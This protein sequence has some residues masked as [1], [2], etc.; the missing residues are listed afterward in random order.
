MLC[1]KVGKYEVKT[2]GPWSGDSGLWRATY[3]IFLI[4]DDKPIPGATGQSEWCKTTQEAH[5]QA[6]E[7]GRQTALK[8]IEIDEKRNA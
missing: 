1:T 8:R 5:R 2:F 3:N 6:E 7:L 4:G